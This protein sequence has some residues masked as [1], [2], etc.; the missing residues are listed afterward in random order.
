MRSMITCQNIFKTYNKNKVIDSFTYSFNENGL[1][2]IYGCSG[3]GKTTLLNIITGNLKYDSGNVSIYEQVFSKKVNHNYAQQN[4]AYITQNNYFIDYL[5]INDNLK[6]CAKSMKGNERIDI[7]LSKMDL[8]DKKKS[9]P[10]ELSGGELQR[11][12]LIIALLQNKKIIILD[13]PTAS[14]DQ[15]SSKLLISILQSL[16]KNHLIICAS[17]DFDLIEKANYKI[18]LT[19]SENYKDIKEKT[20]LVVKN[21]KKKKENFIPLFTFMLKEKFNKKREKKSPIALVIIFTIVILFFYFCYDFSSK[22]EQS[23][24]DYYNVNFV[25]YQCSVSEEDHCDKILQK[26][27]VAYNM[28]LYANNTPYGF[29]CGIDD[30]CLTAQTLPFDK[31][32]FTNYKEKLEYGDYYENENDIILGMDYAKKN[33]SDLA[34]AIGSY[35]EIQMPDKVEKFRVVGILKSVN[36]DIYLKTIVNASYPDREVYLNDKYIQKYEYDGIKKEFEIDNGVVSMRAYFA[37]STDLKEFYN[38]DSLKNVIQV[39][40]YDNSFI[41]IEG[42]TYAIKYYVTPSIIASYIIAILFYYEAE[43]IRSKK[44]NYILSV[45]KYYGHN[46]LHITI[47]YI[48]S[49]II[50]ITFIYFLSF[51]LVTILTPIL[52]FIFI[53]LGLCTFKLFLINKEYLL[54]LYTYLIILAVILV[55]PSIFIQVCKG[56]LNTVK[57]GDNF[58]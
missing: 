37:N 15:E 12:S 3:I 13:E 34:S 52:N 29:N 35:I 58:L 57:E 6:I 47:A 16:S 7:L 46:Y 45:Y 27:N 49:S 28:Y 4:I 33:Y 55:F 50:Y 5:N 38:D 18:D 9:Y 1:Y 54:N 24:L 25:N 53:K 40:K 41:D 8:L 51:I 30:I 42:I 39:I 36:D 44:K 56:W 2:V 43:I 31:S 20:E 17:H 11:V 32:L 48:V 21:V 19:N 26:Y 23:L 22:L 10:N 14:L